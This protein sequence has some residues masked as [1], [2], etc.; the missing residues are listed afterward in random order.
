MLITSQF[1]A[2]LESPNMVLASLREADGS[3]FLFLSF[4]KPRVSWESAR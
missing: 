1:S 3:N 4:A 2:W